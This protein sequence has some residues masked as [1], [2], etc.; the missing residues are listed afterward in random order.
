MVEDHV[1]LRADAPID[2]RNQV[3]EPLLDQLEEPLVVDRRA[4]CR[5]RNSTAP[6]TRPKDEF[7]VPNRRAPWNPPAFRGGVTTDRSPSEG[8]GPARAQ[9][10]DVRLGQLAPADPSP[11][12][13]LVAELASI[14][15]RAVAFGDEV[16]AWVVH[17]AIGRLLGLAPTPERRAS[18]RR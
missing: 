4:K 10:A 18:S 12:A 11:R 13:A 9:P 2:A 15:S 17:E 8:A 3:V 16:T 6:G 7:A 14:L 5:G 1:H